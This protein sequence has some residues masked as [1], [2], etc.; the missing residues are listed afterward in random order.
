M[1]ASIKH[2]TDKKVRYNSLLARWTDGLYYAA[3]LTKCDKTNKRCR[4]CFEDGSEIWVSNRDLHIQLSIDQVS[5]DEDIVCCICDDGN[6]E[7]PNEII[8]CDVC[9]QGYH[10]RC[11]IPPVDSSKLDESDDTKDHKDW[12]CATCSYILNQTNRAKLSAVVTQ[13]QQQ[14]QQQQKQKQQQPQQ[15]AQV[16]P[17]KV[18]TQQSA[19]SKQTPIATTT[20]A[21]SASKSTTPAPKVPK[22]PPKVKQTPTSQEQQSQQQIGPQAASQPLAQPPSQPQPHSTSIPIPKPVPN[23]T[24]QQQLAPK[25]TVGAVKSTLS[26][27]QRSAPYYPLSSQARTVVASASTAALAS[28]TASSALVVGSIAGRSKQDIVKQSNRSTQRQPQSVEINII[29]PNVSPTKHAVRKSSI[30]YVVSP[31]RQS[32]L[33]TATRSVP[34]PTM[35]PNGPGNKESI[36]TTLTTSASEAPKTSAAQV[37]SGPNKQSPDKSV[38]QSERVDKVVSTSNTVVDDRKV[39]NEAINNGSAQ[40]SIS[41]NVSS[42]SVV[43]S[44]VKVIYNSNS[45]KETKQ[46]SE[47]NVHSTSECRHVSAPIVQQRQFESLTSTGQSAITVPKTD[48]ITNNDSDSTT[49]V[50]KSS[51]IIV[52]ATSSK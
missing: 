9:Q 50:S 34:S 31:V 18:D 30:N 4:V 15:P 1:P 35:A 5:D 6:S 33:P 14:Q 46:T 2:L 37:I 38:K 24:S 21:T 43:T 23:Q 20:P 52:S 16:T 39:A 3:A 12:F 25:S 29:E 48:L 42:S 22:Q 13:Q 40:P 36:V 44:N 17:A 19:K 10:Q 7:P 26:A 27:H 45:S 8:L 49:T 51:N 28:M 41:T 32:A 11:H 47:S